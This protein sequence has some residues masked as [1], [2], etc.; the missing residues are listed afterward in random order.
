MEEELKSLYIK[1]TQKDYTMSFKLSVVLEMETTGIGF[2]KSNKF[3][4]D[5]ILVKMYY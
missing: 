3:L 1:R 2:G 4:S 5:A